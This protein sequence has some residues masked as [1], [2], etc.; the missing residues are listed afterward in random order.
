MVSYMSGTHDF[1][2]NI[3][4]KKCGLYTS[5][6]VIKVSVANNGMTEIPAWCSFEDFFKK[7]EQFTP[8]HCVQCSSTLN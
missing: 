3:L 1:E 8:F 2:P 4:A 7:I 5:F 6:M